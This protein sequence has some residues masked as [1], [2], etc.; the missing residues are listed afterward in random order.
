M[1]NF[2]YF[3]PTK[4]LF[5]K[6]TEKEVGALLA[7][8]GAKKVLLHYGQGS[9]ER[10]GLLA[11]VEASIAEAGIETLVLGGVQPNPLLSLVY[12][13]IELCK[14]EKVDFVLAVGGGSA[15]DSAKAIGYGCLYDGDVWDFFDGKA[16]PEACLPIG[17]VLTIAAAGSEMSNSCVITND[18]TMEK[19]GL[20]S[21][22][23]RCRFAVMNPE[24]TMT[25]PPYQ[26]AVGVADILMHTLERYFTPET[27]MMLTQG[28]A[29]SLLCTVME[30]GRILT[31]KPKD[32]NAR[33][34]LMWAGS[35]SHNGLMSC[36]GGHGDWACHQLSHE[37]SAKYGLA[38]G[39]SLTAVWGSWARYVCKGEA[40]ARF[41]RLATQVL[42][43]EPLASE[44]ETAQAGI[45]AMEEYFWSLEL[46]TSLE[47]ADLD[48]TDKEIEDMAERCTFYGRRTVGALRVLKREDVAT[49]YKMARQGHID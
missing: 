29:E 20:G 21:D 43:V 13:G 37:L 38:H 16:V 41:A 3:T 17:A 24:L 39:A 35:L 26:T 40:V 33:A 48:P 12:E 23:S 49:I 19:R 46:P 45:H 14:K 5:G 44:V 15:I 10:S 36:G 18:R 25:L 9:V 2:T 11:R 27:P 30:N 6:D 22:A 1:I 47:E 34:E 42:D 32:Y 7:E 28:L 8:C 31:R 4:V